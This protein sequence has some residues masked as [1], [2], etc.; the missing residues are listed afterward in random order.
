MDVKMTG[1]HEEPVIPAMEPLSC[2]HGGAGEIAKRIQDAV[3]AD[4]DLLV[5]NSVGNLCN[6]GSL[7]SFCAC[8]L[9][10]KRAVS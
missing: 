4:S 1:K 10:F 6:K 7:V 9:G 2:P 5:L 3:P 8:I